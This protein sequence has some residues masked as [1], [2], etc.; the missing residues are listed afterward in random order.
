MPASGHL[1]V[2]AGARASVRF[3]GGAVK[4][5]VVGMI[6]LAHGRARAARSRRSAEEQAWAA[7]QDARAA[8]LGESRSCARPLR[9]GAPPRRGVDRSGVITGR[10]AASCSLNFGNAS[11][12][13]R[14][15]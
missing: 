12:P 11:L 15:K 14:E 2:R 1:G 9:R 13:L 5:A 3:R 6:V 8:G 4:Q 10:R 7:L